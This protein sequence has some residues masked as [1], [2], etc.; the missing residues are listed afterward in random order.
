MDQ[1]MHSMNMGQP[2]SGRLRT[3][4]EVWE[5]AGLISPDTAAQALRPQTQDSEPA[6]RVRRPA[7]FAYLA[8]ISGPAAA[9][10]VADA[11]AGPGSTLLVV[12]LVLVAWPKRNLL[13]PARRT[14]RGRSAAAGTEQRVGPK[15]PQLVLYD[16]FERQGQANTLVP[17]S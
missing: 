11:Y 4:I 2:V 8:A 15:A 6:P 17:T 5:R 16:R 13:A 9:W 1:K 7:P 3:L 10:L 12:L 14:R